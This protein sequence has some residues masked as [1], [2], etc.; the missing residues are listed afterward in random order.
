MKKRR[1]IVPLGDESGW[2]ALNFQGG[3]NV[4]SGS[5]YDLVSQEIKEYVKGLY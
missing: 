4:L 2:L 3:M 1:C 5:R